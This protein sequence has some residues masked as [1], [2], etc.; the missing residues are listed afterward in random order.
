MIFKWQKTNKKKWHKH[1]LL[2]PRVFKENGSTVFACLCFVERFYFEDPHGNWAGDNN[3]WEY[4][5][6]QK[7]R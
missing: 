7:V 4:R 3:H 1:F 2:F 6:I 5:T